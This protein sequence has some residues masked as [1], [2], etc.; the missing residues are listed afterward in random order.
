MKREL[1]EMHIAM[2]DI[3]KSLSKLVGKAEIIHQKQGKHSLA[4][5]D[6]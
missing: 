3:Y 5:E 6:F 1:Q 2:E 4:L